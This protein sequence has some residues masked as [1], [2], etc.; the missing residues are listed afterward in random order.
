[1]RPTERYH[2]DPEFAA[3]VDRCAAEV[4]EPV[5]EVLHAL[6]QLAAHRARPFPTVEDIEREWNAEARRARIVYGNNAVDHRPGAR[7][8]GHKPT[9]PIPRWARGRQRRGAAG[10]PGR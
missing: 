3:L 10:R 4:T 7:R 5:G 9:P 2:A 8:P 6:E 1:M